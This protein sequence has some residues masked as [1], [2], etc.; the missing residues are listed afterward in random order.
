[1]TDTRHL[2]LYPFPPQGRGSLEYVI[3]RLKVRYYYVEGLFYRSTLTRLT[4]RSTSVR[5]TF[6][7]NTH[8]KE[9][10]TR[11]L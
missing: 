9:R 3:R 4:S 7:S 8:E 11:E 10:P 2:H 1:M 5:L 6:L